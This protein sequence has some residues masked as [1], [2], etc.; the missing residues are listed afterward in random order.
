MTAVCRPHRQ[1]V[2]LAM[3]PN[4]QVPDLAVQSAWEL[5]GTTCLLLS[6]SL[7]QA[8]AARILRSRLASQSLSDRTCA[9][10]DSGTAARSSPAFHLI[11]QRQV[12]CC[13][14]LSGSQARAHA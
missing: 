11:G 10:A 1:R 5:A 8:L 3:R 14:L 6:G 9:V 13:V 7:S 4:A 12:A 2:P